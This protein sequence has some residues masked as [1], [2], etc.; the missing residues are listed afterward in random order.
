M[1]ERSLSTTQA[2]ATIG[3]ASNASA[4]TSKALMADRLR[5]V[6]NEIEPGN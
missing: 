1:A 6:S 3:S 4:K 5:E 2:D